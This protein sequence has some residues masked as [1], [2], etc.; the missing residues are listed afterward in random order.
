MSLIR[1]HYKIHN[2]FLLCYLSTLEAFQ[3][4]LLET[5]LY[6]QEQVLGAT[7]GGQT[8]DL[9]LVKTDAIAMRYQDDNDV[10][11]AMFL[12]YAETSGNS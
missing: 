2:I 5:K 12:K 9:P 11:Y 4:L 10:R 6:H 7:S 8:R 1:F 3:C